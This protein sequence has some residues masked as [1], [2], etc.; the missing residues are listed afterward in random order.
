MPEEA[1]DTG[2]PTEEL[3][4]LFLG[5]LCPYLFL[6]LHGPLGPSL[7]N[8]ASPRCH[9]NRL[10]WSNPH[11]QPLAQVAAKDALPHSCSAGQLR[12]G[13]HTVAG[14]TAEL[15]VAQPGLK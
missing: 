13:L 12:G 4:T 5:L 8:S 11:L 2:L 14:L 9:G 15:H 6:L 7:L 3:Q 10:I 1:V